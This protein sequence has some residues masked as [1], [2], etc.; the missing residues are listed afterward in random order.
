[1]AATKRQRRELSPEKRDA[2]LAKLTIRGKKYFDRKDWAKAAKY[3]VAA[4]D[5]A[6]EDKDLLVIVSHL[7][8][9]LG[10]R[11][12][13]ILVLEKALEVNGP[14]RDVLSIMGEMA[15]TM[16]MHDIAEKLA[17]IYIEQFPDDPVG[18]NTLANALGGQEKFDQSIEMM[19]LMLPIFE[20][21]ANLWNTLGSHVS[22]RDGYA[23]S[24]VF[25]EQ[26]AKLAPDDYRIPNN[27]ARTY[28]YMDNFEA[29][30]IWS[31]RS[32]ELKPGDPE[33]TL[34]LGT[35]QLTLGNLK[36]GW[37]YYQ[38][39]LDP[40]RTGQVTHYT[41]KI[42]DWDG[43]DLAGKSIFLASEQ[44][45]GD[46]ILFGLVIPRVCEEAEKVY[47]G[48]D[49]RLMSVFERSF[50]DV[51]VYYASDI[52]Q[53]GYIYRRF[54]QFEA[55]LKAGE[56]EVDCSAEYGSIP[57][58]HWKTIEEIPDFPDGLLK[59]DPELVAKWKARLDELSDRPKIGLAW[60]SGKMTADRKRAYLA[61]EDMAPLFKLA[62]TEGGRDGVDFINLQYGD[63]SEEL[64]LVKEKFG[65]TV[66]AWDD[67][68]LKDD[69]E[70]T[71][72]LMKNIDLT[73]GAGS[74]P[75]MMSMAV[76][77]PVW[78]MVRQRPWWTFGTGAVPFHPKGNITTHPVGTAWA[79]KTPEVAARLAR[80]IETDDFTT[81]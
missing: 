55:R 13:A 29:A 57:Q 4:W 9:Q 63:C 73:I 24:I 37:K 45:L 25:Y 48:C 17:N 69:F 62:R 72:A 18:Y 20:D 7:L 74:S 78:W 2:K 71:L 33:P 41:H 80:A 14:T 21:N 53:H 31:E 51:E 56:I 35:A 23:E 36:D 61:V 26:A 58:F 10:V 11:E 34:G 54:P 30:A 19:Q 42:P 1:M 59:L 32:L 40:R 46:E 65:V 68:N 27:L 52:T 81:E 16:Q 22:M 38:A 6:P 15:L 3:Y 50:P 64:A 39:R 77:I 67:L 76:G 60:R 44:G 5:M 8:V 49:K 79:E 75:A 43:S 28:E 66:H 12:K 47:I 70:N